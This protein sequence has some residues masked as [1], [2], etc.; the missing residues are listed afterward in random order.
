M[1]LAQVLFGLKDESWLGIAI[2]LF[3]WWVRLAIFQYEAIKYDMYN[4]KYKNIFR[5]LSTIPKQTP[6]SYNARKNKFQQ[7]RMHE[8]TNFSKL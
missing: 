1:R 4:S 5:I 8:R 3:G 2:F 6:A 7:V